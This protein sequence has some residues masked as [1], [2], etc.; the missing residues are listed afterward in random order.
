MT[1][2]DPP[3]WFREQAPPSHVPAESEL[4]RAV[5]D[6]I[7]PTAIAEPRRPA[8]PGVIF[9]GEAPSLP[10]PELV[11]GMLPCVGVAFLGGQSGAGK[12]F[13]AIDLAIALATK[14]DFFGRKV[15]ARVGV[16]VVAAEG[17]GTL[18]D[19]ISV[20]RRHRG[21]P[22][23]LPIATIGLAD[24]LTHETARQTL[25]S[26]LFATDA[27]FCLDYECEMGIVIIDTLAA[28]FSIRDENSNG[29]AS[30]IM[31][32]LSE[33]SRATKSLVLAVHHYGKSSETGL[34]GASAYRA[35]ADAVISVLGKRDE[36]AGTCID[37]SL[38][39]AKSRTGTEGPVSGFDLVEIELGENQYG[40]LYGSCAVKPTNHAG[41]ARGRPGNAAHRAFGE[42]FEC[43]LLECGDAHR[44]NGGG[45][46][47]RAVGVDRVREEYLRRKV[48]GEVDARTQR[49][50]ATKAFRRYLDRLPAE[51]ATETTSTGEW[52]WRPSD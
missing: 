32:T 12:T 40:E 26:L 19:R 37:R 15:R 52:I 21:A 6:F 30:A 16:V 14:T 20:A 17:A 5:L 23:N 2:F 38:A 10:A 29:E 35:G 28:A 25:L 31:R 50:T 8:I 47:I 22:Q 41:K 45:P 42:A 18:P 33:I 24:D 27:R 13:V 36:V 48:T 7:Q 49:E 39:I 4:S 44:L 3:E 9:D 46:I 34:R 11:Q 51:Y 43:A 1:T